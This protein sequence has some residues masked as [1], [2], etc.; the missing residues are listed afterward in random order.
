M[1]NDKALLVATQIA[2]HVVEQAGEAESAQR[3]LEVLD[4]VG[5]VTRWA[6]E[7]R[8]MLKGTNDRVV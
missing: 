6:T 8:N 3:I 7:T 2:V 1:Q 5:I 4:W